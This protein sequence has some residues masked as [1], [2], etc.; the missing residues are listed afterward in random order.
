M[1]RTYPP[2]VPEHPARRAALIRLDDVLHIESA[3]NKPI[4][5]Q[6][7]H[8]QVTRG[9]EEMEKTKVAAGARIWKI[10]SHNWIV[11]TP[12]VTI[13]FDLVPG[14]PRNDGFALP[15]ALLERIVRQADVLFI[16]HLHADHANKGVARMFLQQWKRVVAPEGLWKGD[17]EFEGRLVYPLRSAE[18]VHRLRC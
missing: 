18:T 11:R 3:P 9:V 12:S 1:F 5:Q 2:A 7:F 10:Y 8:S 4:V 6:F 15:A 14:P 13:A 17:A 16:S